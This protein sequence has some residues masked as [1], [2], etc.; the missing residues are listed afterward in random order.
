MSVV[1]TRFRAARLIAGYGAIAAAVPYLALK[2]VWLGGGSLGVADSR[3]MGEPSMLALNAIT[4]A[5]DLVGVALALA[6]THRWGQRLPA[7]LLLP[8]IWVATGL[9]VRFVIGVP[10]A[11]ILEAFRSGAVLRA[12]GPVEPWVYVV[13]YIGFAGMGIGLLTAFFLYARTRWAA[14]LESTMHAVQPGATRD[15]QVVLANGAAMLALVLSA[16]HLAWAFGAGSLVNGIDAV[17][18]M[19][20]AA[21]ILM[22]AHRIGGT[23]R[24]W[25]PLTMTWIGG[26]SMF[27]WGLWQ[28]INVL[29]QTAL[30]RGTQG[31]AL[32]N[33]VGL[34][35]LIVG[36]LLG[37]LTVFV[38]AE[39][40]AQ[41]K[42]T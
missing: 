26:G 32:V 8:P 3:L 33:L 31:M 23:V 15:V 41:M 12:G 39:R 19:G 2:I 42:A 37:L 28:M 20:A 4:A 17:M 7:W 35:R 34:S 6:F 21:G 22:M 40:H 13:V 25:L 30:M 27:A 18:M 1:S 29:G 38:V 10:I 24:F 9:L 11:G 14:T 16:L 36:M 5:M